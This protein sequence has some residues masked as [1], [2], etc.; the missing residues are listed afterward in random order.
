MLSLDTAGIFRELFWGLLP[1]SK[2]NDKIKTLKTALSY[3]TKYL[4]PARVLSMEICLMT[5]KIQRLDKLLDLH[6]LKD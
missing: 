3:H 5:A 2:F 1:L 6:V 4:I